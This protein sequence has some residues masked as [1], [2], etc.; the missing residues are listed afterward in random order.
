MSPSI[1]ANKPGTAIQA[2]SSTFSPPPTHGSRSVAPISSFRNIDTARSHVSQ[3]RASNWLTG[4][5]HASLARGK[6]G[7]KV[8][9]DTAPADDDRNPKYQTPRRSHRAPRPSPRG[10]FYCSAPGF[11]DRDRRHPY[12]RI[13]GR[14][15]TP[16]ARNHILLIDYN[17]DPL[18][19]LSTF[20]A[21]RNP[22]YIRNT[23]EHVVN[24]TR[25]MPET[26]SRSC[27]S[28]HLRGR[29]FLRSA[30]GIGR[31]KGEYRRPLIAFGFRDARDHE[32]TDWTL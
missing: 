31:F 8:Y 17:L 30:A 23:S 25:T 7:W 4:S 24:H 2:S 18:I 15:G 29:R 13:R 1:K 20:H 21:N 9:E 19:S 32:L 11:R 27:R 6:G 22:S 28:S 26:R 14:P 10:L 3:A 5:D 16:R 12:T